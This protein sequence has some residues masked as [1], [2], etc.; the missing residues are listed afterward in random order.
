VI[1]EDGVAEIRRTGAQEN[2]FLLLEQTGVILVARAH[3][4]VVSGASAHALQRP[5]LPVVA[6]LRLGHARDHLAQLAG[7]VV[8]VSHSLSLLAGQADR[9]LSPTRVVQQLARSAAP[10]SL[11]LKPQHV[12][13]RPDLE[14]V[15]VTCRGLDAAKATAATDLASSLIGHLENG[16][17]AGDDS[18]GQD[19]EG[20]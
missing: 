4:E 1:A 15:N 18:F 19:L 13:G 8:G 3:V 20:V 5:R 9:H 12:D 6:E 11:V 16:S 10:G 14:R 2:D 17:L 7:A